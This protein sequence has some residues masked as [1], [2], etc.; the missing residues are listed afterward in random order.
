M[1]HAEFTLPA[2]SALTGDVTAWREGRAPTSI[3]HLKK[4]GPGTENDPAGVLDLNEVLQYGLFVG[5]PELSKKL[6]EL[7]NLLHGSLQNTD[8]YISLGNTDGVNKVF[9]LFV[10]PGDTVLAEEFSFT[11][12][13]NA[14]R[15]KGAN[16][17]PIKMDDKGIIPEDLDRVLSTWSNR[18]KPRLLY[19]IPCGQNPTGS[20]LPN[21]RYGAVYAIA[22]KHDVLM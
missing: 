5:Y 20:V 16:I 9:T 19:T 1:Q 17:H 8:V 22:Q 11:N 18:P 10:E 4:T 2:Y 14:A 6:V 3:A 7:N 12:S 21:D 15:A 13:L